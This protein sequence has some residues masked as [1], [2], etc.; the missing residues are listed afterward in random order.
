M[1]CLHCLEVLPVG[2]AADAPK[3]HIGPG[4]AVFAD[5]TVIGAIAVHAPRHPTS[6]WLEGRD[7]VV[8]DDEMRETTTFTGGPDE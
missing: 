8:V 7:Y 2:P 3:I 4:R 1:K 5:P 6:A